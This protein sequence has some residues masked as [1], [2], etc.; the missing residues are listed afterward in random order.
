MK[1]LFSREF[2]HSGTS[3]IF[4]W[5]VT[6]KVPIGDDLHWLIMV[7]NKM[8]NPQN[9]DSAGFFPVTESIWIG[10]CRGGQIRTDDLLVPN[11]ARY[12]A[13]LHP[14]LLKK[15]LRVQI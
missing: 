11:E 8:K 5:E 3:K 12:R 2:H 14:E 7:R 6:L 4:F 10:V 1:F 13:T 9:I 15:N